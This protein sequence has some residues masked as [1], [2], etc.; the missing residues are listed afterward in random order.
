MTG[1]AYMTYI[2]K[3][4]GAPNEINHI[5]ELRDTVRC[6]KYSP[7]THS[8]PRTIHGRFPQRWFAMELKLL[9]VTA[10]LSVTTWLL[11][12]LAVALQEQRR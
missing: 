1:I 6:D 3:R 7:R 11:Y 5:R 2:P 9:I 12:R 10:L 4:N 8:P